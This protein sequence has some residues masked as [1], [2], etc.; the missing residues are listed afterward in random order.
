[1]SCIR[2]IPATSGAAE[3]VGPRVW[4]AGRDLECDF[5]FVGA[6]SDRGRVCVPYAS[7]KDLGCGGDGQDVCA[8]VVTT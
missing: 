8:G 6:N 1:M 2:T 4:C 3:A 5:G 7:E